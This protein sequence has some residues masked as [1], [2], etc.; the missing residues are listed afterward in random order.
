MFLIT[1]N[2][3][4]ISLGCICCQSS[5]HGGQPRLLM[6]HEH[7]HEDS[8]VPH[9]FGLRGDS[10]HI[11][12]SSGPTLD[13]SQPWQQSS[14][15]TAMPW[16]LS[17][18]HDM[19]TLNSSRLSRLARSRHHIEAL[20]SRTTRKPCSG[21]SNHKRCGVA[22]ETPVRQRA[23]KSLQRGTNTPSKVAACALLAATAAQRTG[24]VEASSPMF[25]I[26]A[27]VSKAAFV[28]RFQAAMLRSS[29]ACTPAVASRSEHWEL[30]RAVSDATRS[31]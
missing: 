4:C 12:S 18:D 9:A 22:A 3:A 25:P 19:T 27:E 2:N 8:N 14:Y 7:G 23:P 17:R 6:H 15:R 21:H 11:S 24:T 28:W 16:P 31:T 29:S 20:L 30:G 10:Y 26:D 5:T 13:Q 1:T